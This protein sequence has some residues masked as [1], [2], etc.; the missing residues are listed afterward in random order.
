VEPPLREV[1]EERRSV[2]RGETSPLVSTPHIFFADCL[3]VSVNE[4]E[5]D[6][7]RRFVGNKSQQYRHWWVI[8]HT[9]RPKKSQHRRIEKS[10]ISA[11]KKHCSR[12]TYDR[13]SERFREQAL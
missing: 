1:P 10:S 2:G 5:M 13:R 3:L 12:E 7:M 9:T 6:E 11:R 4:T 8:K